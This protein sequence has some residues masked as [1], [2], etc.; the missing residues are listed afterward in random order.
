MPSLHKVKACTEGTRGNL[1]HDPH[2]KNHP[3]SSMLLTDAP[4]N[5]ASSFPDNVRRVFFALR[6]NK[7]VQHPT[8]GYRC[9][10]YTWCHDAERVSSV[11]SSRMRV[12]H[13]AP[14]D[15][16]DELWAKR[17][18]SVF[19]F[20]TNHLSRRN[21]DNFHPL[22]ISDFRYVLV[23]FCFVAALMLEFVS[24]SPCPYCAVPK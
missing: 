3:F 22:T 15:M 24:G 6:T 5:P 1:D 4:I 17:C 12:R 16:P 8:S 20:S 19:G 14:T 2:S 21:V 7:C 23:S 11:S 18:V 10:F 9:L 13:I